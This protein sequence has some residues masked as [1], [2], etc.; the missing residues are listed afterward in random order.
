M[1]EVAE[2]NFESFLAKGKLVEMTFYK[3]KEKQGCV[4]KVSSVNEDMK[5][6]WDLSYDGKKVDVK[7]IKGIVRYDKPNE[8]YHHIELTNI[9][10]LPG[11]LF[12]SADEFAFECEDYF[13]IVTAADLKALIKRKLKH[14]ICTFPTPYEV[15]HRAGNK[16]ST[17]LA[18]TI[19]IIIIAKEILF[20]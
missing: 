10:G 19:D 8:N 20:K 13:V 1:I 17:T 14:K 12:G 3:L 2:N 11:W 18:K 6:H 7:A 5:E 4:M 15:Y 16:D 9:M